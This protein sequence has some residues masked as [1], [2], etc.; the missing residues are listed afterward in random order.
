MR[1]NHL[2]IGAGIFG[3]S[4]AIEL[5]KRSH[6]VTVINPGQIPHPLAASTDI[7]KVIRMEYGTDLEYMEMAIE[8]M[9]A[10]R[11]W[12]LVLGE[13]VFHETG[14]AILSP[15]KIEDG[16]Q[17]YEKTSWDNLQKKGIVAE[18]LNSEKIKERFPAFSSEKY[19]DGIFNKMAGFAES[20]RAVELLAQY[21]QKT[22]VDIFENNTAEKIIIEN[23]RAVG[24]ETREGNI[25][26][27]ENIIVCA[28][29]F[30]PYLI[31][32]IKPFFKITGHPVFHLKPKDPALFAS[33]DFTVFTAD[34]A[35]T[36]WYGFPLHP[37]EKVVKVALHSEGLELHPAHDERVVYESDEQQLRAFLR[38]SIPALAD[39]PVVFTR[40]CCYTD[41]LDGH[42][43]IDRH[44]A[45]ANL[46]VGS[47][48]SGHGFKMGPA[49]GKMIA[50]VAEGKQHQ[51]S[52][53]YDWR[54][55]DERT[56]QREEARFLER[57]L[58]D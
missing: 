1:T 22:G 45:V 36:G 19:I 14:Y 42:F 48:G 46:V 23:N 3:I 2:I 24:A 20:G 7:S 11:E 10:W 13:T 9:A 26:K 35:N 31:P 54:V 51:W 18:R 37:K 21:A 6:S 33:P 8:S 29:N 55:L 4:A 47:G 34:I 12:N 44:P 16:K 17:V 41:T 32:E 30:T 49:V 53:R 38:S 52:N 58:E 28:G 56:V 43:W 39:A 50:D 40:R 5:R 27:A 57:G 15:N 25:F